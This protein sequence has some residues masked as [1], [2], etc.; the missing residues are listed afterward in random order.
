[1][2]GKIKPILH[3]F[4]VQNVIFLDC[5]TM[6]ALEFCIKSYGYFSFECVCVFVFYK[7]KKY[8]IYYL[9]SFLNKVI[10][11]GLYYVILLF[12]RLEGLFQVY[13]DVSD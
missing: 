6:H 12:P 1:M 11:L 4:Q 5:P 9:S 3:D 10:Y 7:L 2:H 13:N 8:A